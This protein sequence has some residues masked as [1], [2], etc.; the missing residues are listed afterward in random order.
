MIQ[1]VGEDKAHAKRACHFPEG[2]GGG[3]GEEILCSCM[4]SS[5][6]SR[7][8]QHLETGYPSLPQKLQGSPMYL[9]VLVE[10]SLDLEDLPFGDGFLASNLGEGL[11][12]LSLPIESILGFNFCFGFPVD[13]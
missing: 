7:H 3:F 12:E 13:V 8:F 5:K 4:A 10:D 6:A 9:L 1:V 11:E 2:G